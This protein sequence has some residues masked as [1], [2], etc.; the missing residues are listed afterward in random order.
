MPPLAA[1]PAIH[2]DPA[3]DVLIVGAGAFGLWTARACRT[4]GLRIEICDAGRVGDAQGASGGPVGALAPHRPSPWTA[5]KA[6]QFEAIRDLPKR[7]A[8]LEAETGCA[9]GAARVGRAAP[10]V[11]AEARLRAEARLP[12]AALRWPGFRQW[13]EDAPPG[14][15]APH[16]VLRDDLTARLAP[17]PTAQA[18]RTALPPQAIRDGD[19]L[20][21]ASDPRRPVLAS[22]PR[23]AGATV[24]AAGVAIRELLPMPALEPEH[25]Q[26]ARLGA[27]LPSGTPL[28]QGPGLWIVPQP[29]QVA[30]GSTSERGR[31]D[32]VT[33]AGLD[34]LIAKAR[35]LLPALAEAPVL[36]RWAGLR[37]RFASRGPL[38]GEVAPGL[39]VATGG[40]KIGLALAPSIGD[41]VAA[42]L[43]GEPNPLAPEFRP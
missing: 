23:P 39:L 11:S 8:A 17:R 7:L 25:G 30:V 42:V 19:P 16:G 34:A 21:D 3:P 10:F 27:V 26:A 18:L 37:P 22:G 33:D 31:E 4:R 41:A 14:L 9:T 40:F 35:A 1:A 2:V 29:D 43:S 20:L 36:E 38:A 28:I 24:L 12:E 6:L 15:V 5:L 32:L 13:I